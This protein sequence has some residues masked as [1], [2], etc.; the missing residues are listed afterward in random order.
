MSVRY[1]R[2]LICLC[3]APINAKGVVVCG[4]VARGP[5]LV[6]VLVVLI[7]WGWLLAIIVLGLSILR[8]YGVSMGISLWVR[9]LL[10]DSGSAWCERERSAARGRL[11]VWRTST[12]E[13]FEAVL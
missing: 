6:G 12:P 5:L 8:H 11:M 9:S 7:L 1:D 3:L 4:I 13:R 2:R 10:C